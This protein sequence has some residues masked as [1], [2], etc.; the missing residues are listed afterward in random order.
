MF[1]CEIFHCCCFSCV[2]NV[3]LHTRFC[4][5]VWKILMIKG[6]SFESSGV[7]AASSVCDWLNN[8][9]TLSSGVRKEKHLFGVFRDWVG[10]CCG[11]GGLSDLRYHCSRC[12]SHTWTL[13]G[14]RTWAGTSTEWDRG[15]QKWFPSAGLDLIVCSSHAVRLYNC[16]SSW[17]C[18]RTSK[19]IA[20]GHAR[21]SSSALK[22][23]TLIRLTL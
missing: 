13:C 12:C 14:W 17:A 15:Q 2:L 20:S 19:F 23:G 9:I 11:S 10:E 22:H 3:C 4:V 5:Y 8:N 21:C 6:S 16:I 7:D 1:W 18:T